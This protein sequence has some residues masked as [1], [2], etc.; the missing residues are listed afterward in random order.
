MYTF[1][2]LWDINLKRAMSISRYSKKYTFCGFLLSEKKKQAGESKTFQTKPTP[3]LHDYHLAN[4]SLREIITL[5]EIEYN[6]KFTFIFIYP[7]QVELNL[8]KGALQWDLAFAFCL[9]LVSCFLLPLLHL[10]HQCL[11]YQ[12]H[13]KNFHCS[14]NAAFLIATDTYS[15]SEN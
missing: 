4:S 2:I 1:F 9:A 3:K 11:L 7:M 6:L 10:I 13:S 5:M 15:I 14:V 8:K 12:P